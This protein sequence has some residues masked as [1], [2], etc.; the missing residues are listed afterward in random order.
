VLVPQAVADMQQVQHLIAAAD[1][2]IALSSTPQCI[3]D[4]TA[5]VQSVV[6]VDSLAAS[7]AEQTEVSTESVET[8]YKGLLKV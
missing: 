2:V 4:D 7:A 3:T 5:T 1:S 6:S 8:I